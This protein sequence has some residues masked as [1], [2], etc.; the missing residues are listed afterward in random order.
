MNGCIYRLHHGIDVP[1]DVIVPKSKHAIAFCRQVRISDSIGRRLGVLPSI[2]FNYDQLLPAKHDE[3]ATYA[4]FWLD[5][6]A[7]ERFKYELQ[8]TL[9]MVELTDTQKKALALLA[10]FIQEAPRTGDEIHARLHAF[11]TDVPIAPK[12]LFSAMYR[13]FLDRDSGPQAGWFLGSL[14]RE[15]VLKRLSEATESGTTDTKN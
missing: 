9:P 4:R 11:K 14:P 12:E 10:S 3:R 6:Y 15:F 7:P 2:D 13:I 5:A 8:E 1:R